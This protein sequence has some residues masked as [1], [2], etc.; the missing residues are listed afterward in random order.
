MMDA[1]MSEKAKKHL[2]EARG[3]IIK[4]GK[5]ICAE[6]YIRWARNRY[7]GGWERFEEPATTD[8][9]GFRNGRWVRLA[10]TECPIVK[11]PTTQWHFSEERG[12]RLLS[13]MEYTKCKNA[14]PRFL[15]R[16]RI[17]RY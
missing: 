17:D 5:R 12:R 16:R 13:L 1:M 10:R 9:W 4:H 6:A 14:L 11:N 8:R 7:Q 2:K 15:D 3:R